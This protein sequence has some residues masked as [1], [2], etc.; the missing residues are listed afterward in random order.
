MRFMG[1]LFALWALAVAMV[2]SPEMLRPVQ[3]AVQGLLVRAAWAAWAPVIGV[4]NYW[5]FYYHLFRP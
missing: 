4:D 5:Q 1:F 3:E 2:Q